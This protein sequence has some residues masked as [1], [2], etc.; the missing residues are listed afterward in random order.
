MEE[1]SIKIE[2]F[3]T[4]SIKCPCGK[5]RFQLPNVKN[6]DKVVCGFCG[7][8]FEVVIKLLVSSPK[9]KNIIHPMPVKGLTIS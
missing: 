7:R 1:Q 8:E 9:K 5:T 4:T 3:T 6:G 2:S